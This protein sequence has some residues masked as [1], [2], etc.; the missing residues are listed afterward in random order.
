MYQKSLKYISVLFFSTSVS[1]YAQEE[2]IATETTTETIAT[3]EFGIKTYT[4]G[5]ITISGNIYFN[6]MTIQTF[7]G[8]QKG[9]NIHLPGDELSDTIKKL[10]N[11]EYFSDIKI[12]EKNI[13]GNVLDIEIYLEELP[14]LKNVE[15]T[16]LKKSKKEEILK[17]MK[18]AYEETTGKNNNKKLKIIEGKIINENLIA[19][20][21]NFLLNKYRKNGYY[22]AQVEIKTV[23]SPTNK[24]EAS[25]HI[26]INKG[27]KVRIEK[28]QFNGNNQ[29]ADG[30]LKKSM[31][32]T[33]QRSPLNPLRIFTPSKFIAKEYEKDLENLVDKYK[34]NGF[35]DAR[36]VSEKATYNPQTN[37]MN[38]DI[39]IEEG[40]KYFIGDIRF[41]GNTV[42]SDY[43]LKRVI[44]F[45]KG[46]LYNGVLLNKRVNDINDPDG[47]NI[48]NMYQNNGYL[49]SRI[50]LL[51]RQTHNDTIDF[52]V[53]ISEGTVARF[54]NVTV[55]GNDK[56]KD[57]I[58]L[59]ELSTIPGQKWDRSNIFESMRRLQS[60]NIFDAQNIVPDVKNADP[61]SSTVDIDWQVV[62]HGQSQ[63][64][65]Q[66]GYGGRTFIGTVALSFNNFSIRNIFNKK[67]Y[68]PFPMGDAQKFSVRAQASTYFTTLSLSFQEP[69]FGGRKPISLFGS[70]SYSKQSAFDPYTYKIDRSQGLAITSVNIGLAK[71]LS[72]PIFTL[73]HSLSYQNY[74]LNNYNLSYLAFNNGYSK[75]LAYNIELTR[76]NRGGLHPAIFPSA[77]SIMSISGKFTFP[78]SLVNGVNYAD[79]ENQRE[80]KTVTTTLT[81]HP[82][83]GADIP[84]GTYIDANGY[85][86]ADYRDAAPNQ[87]K[88]DQKRFNWLEYYKFNFKADWYTLLVDKLVLRS[89]GQFGFIGAYNQDRGLIP[90]ERYFLGGSGMMNFALDGRENIALRG[91]EDNQL[92]QKNNT[93]MP[94][95]GT[96]YNKFSLELRYP[97]TLKA[98]MSAFILGFFDAGAVYNDF[99][100]YKPF[101]LQRSTGAG[102][103]VFMPMIGLLGMDFGYG[104]DKVPGTNRIGGWQTHFILGQQF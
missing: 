102:V 67:A 57:Y 46:D 54:N 75:N 13:I 39:Q 10:W 15:I 45:E 47:N 53:R 36:V 11:L 58:I 44:G 101:Q 85:P 93:G 52:D 14:R 76:D 6:P 29:L 79:L 90:F 97:I 84:I 17:E 100:T 18:F 20:T 82:V 49:F 103:R 83:T 28:I 59:R 1:L 86:V 98:Q 40:K 88:I 37:R 70:I 27:K 5:E 30:K 4:L 72:D 34:E 63:V 64:E 33:K 24:K 38:I 23:Q 78:Y 55:S 74:N 32:K 77:G 35:R 43:Q 21:R 89:T 48:G 68:T 62:E 66:G 16:G 94:I 7:T 56:T 25:L 91:Y 96:A 50:N 60:M 87:T 8:L 99:K 22:N 81:S 42:Y 80:Y 9:Q 26:D 73:S 92:N 41:I 95:G 19:N 65:V 3:D 71:R 104:F 2:T 51:E 31:K 61:V 69:W 12:Y